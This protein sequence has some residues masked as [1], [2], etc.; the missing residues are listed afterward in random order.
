MNDFA[1]F[2]RNLTETYAKVDATRIDSKLFGEKLFSRLCESYVLARE[3]SNTVEAWN[4][5]PDVEAILRDGF[6]RNGKSAAPVFLLTVADMSRL[7]SDESS[8]V[9]NLIYFF[10]DHL[11]TKKLT[12]LNFQ[13]VLIVRL[14]GED[15]GRGS[16]LD[17]DDSIFFRVQATLLLLI[18]EFGDGAEVY[19][20]RGRSVFRV[21]WDEETALSNITFRKILPAIP[22][23]LNGPF[24]DG[25][26][27]RLLLHEAQSSS[28]AFSSEEIRN[29]FQGNL[30]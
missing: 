17:Y 1:S 22:I 8:D 20:C 21:S 26:G 19:V 27:Y 6:T 12:S 30:C 3:I 7:R 5:E 10:L 18:A 15:P 13:S 23:A 11:R 2:C 29:L 25:N 24:S 16:E 28:V 9:N 4:R 14:M